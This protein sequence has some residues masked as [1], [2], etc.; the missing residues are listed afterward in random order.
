MLSQIN[1][2]LFID[3][4]GTAGLKDTQSKLYILAGCSINE[5]ERDQ[6]KIRAD[7]IKFKYWGRTD[8]VFHSREI[9][10]KENDFEILKNHK[11]K[12][13]FFKDIED[14]LS[15]TGFKL[16]FVIVDKEKAREQNWNSNK[17]YQ[18]TSNIIVKNFLLVLLSQNST[19]KIIIESAT[20]EKDFY[21]YKA[22]GFFLANGLKDLHVDYR[23]V[24]KTLTSISFVTKNNFDIEE[25]ISDLFAYAAKCQ[26]YIRSK[27]KTHLGEYEKIM[28]SLLRK[29]IYKIPQNA[30]SGKK[31]FLDAIDP[32]VII[33][34]QKR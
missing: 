19:G 25:Q 30:K 23:E 33:P 8:I 3:E 21:F 32:F 22:T 27:R 2:K 10:R 18:E 5:Q 14:L 13:D 1:Y 34:K 9:G 29:K 31:K 4:L 7:Q 17:I 16:F 20:A 11:T 12:N 26:F 6:L 15:E 28:I 24:Q